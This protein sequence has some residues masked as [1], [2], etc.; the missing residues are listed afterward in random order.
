MLSEASQEAGEQSLFPILMNYFSFLE[1]G[2]DSRAHS[3]LCS[4]LPLT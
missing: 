4:A 2:R 1:N 3:L